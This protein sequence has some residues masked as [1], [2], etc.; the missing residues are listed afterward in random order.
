MTSKALAENLSAP[1]AEVDILNPYNA[2][3]T[4]DD[5]LTIVDVKAHDTARPAATP[6]STQNAR[7]A[8][9]PPTSV[10]ARQTRC[11]FRKCRVRGMP[12]RLK[13]A[14]P[15]ADRSPGRRKFRTAARRVFQVKIQR[16]VFPD[17]APRLLYARAD[18]YSR[19]LRRR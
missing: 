16:L 12:R 8:P 9:G 15:G 7:R 10:C 13:S 14:V 1:V 6:S 5:K 2:R 19:R 11:G 18:L 3:E 17:P 4:L